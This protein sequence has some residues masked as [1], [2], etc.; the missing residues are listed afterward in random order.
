MQRPSCLKPVTLVAMGDQSSN[1][2]LYFERVP[3]KDWKLRDAYK[4]YKHKLPRGVN[5][6]EAIKRDLLTVKNTRKALTS[7]ADSILEDLDV[8][9]KI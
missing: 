8:G 1:R 7:S 4:E 3:K 9:R 5:I 6:Y 2:A